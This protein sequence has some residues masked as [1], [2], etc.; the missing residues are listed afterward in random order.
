[1]KATDPF[2]GTF[3]LVPPGDEDA[4]VAVIANAIRNGFAIVLDKPDTKI[5]M[6]ILNARDAKA[7]DREVQDAARGLGDPRWHLR[8]HACGLHHA[9]TVESL[10]GD[11]AKVRGK[12]SAIVRRVTRLHGGR[13]PNIGVEPGRSRYL[14]VDVDTADELNAFLATWARADLGDLGRAP[15]IE[16]TVR[17]PGQVDEEGN[18]VHADGG[19]FWFGLPADVELPM[20]SQGVYRH[21]SGWTAMW[22]AHQILVPPSKRPEGV[23]TIVGQ[24]HPAPRWL[25][26]MIIREAT[27]RADR[28][29]RRMEDL[30]DGSGE[31][32]VWS[33]R[34]SW[35]ELLEPDGWT[36]TG[37]P[38]RCSCP[39]FT[40]PGPH[41]SKKSATGHD[42]GCD[43]YDSSTGHAPLHI[44][45][46][47]PP[48]E[49]AEAIRATGTKTFTK[50]QYVAWAAGHGGDIGLAT[51]DL[52]MSSGTVAGASLTFDPALD[53]DWEPDPPR[54]KR[55]EEPQDG[56]GDAGDPFLAPG[57]A[58]PDSDGSESPT[59]AGDDPE[60]EEGGSATDEAKELTRVD[61]LRA[62]M[63]GS[64]ALD[65]IEDPEPLI[66]GFL[67]L[68]TVA[69]VTGKSGHGKSFVMLD[70]ACS[71]AT[72][73]PW[74]GFAT[75]AGPVVYMVAEGLRGVKKR[76]RAWE[77]RH[78]GGQ[79]ISDDRLYLLKIPVQVNDREGWAAFVQILREIGPVMVILD[80]Q[81]R[82]TVGVDEND[83]KEMGIFVDR[84]ELVRRKT[85]ACVITVHHLGHQGEHGRGS[86]AVIGALGSELRVVKPGKGKLVVETSKQKDD[87]ELAPLKFV[88]DPEGDSV[89]PAPDGWVPEELDPFETP[90]FV[91]VPAKIR[92]FRLIWDWL[93]QN[94]QGFTKAEA[95]TVIR[96]R[97]HGGAP[98]E[99]PRVPMGKS[100][101]YRAFGEMVTE[102]WLKPVT[103]AKGTES[104]SRFK[105][106]PKAAREQGFEAP[107]G[108]SEPDAESDE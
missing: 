66:A 106:N 79:R 41:A 90:T 57:A 26:G 83:A 50:I 85:G 108:P 95:W 78:N 61:A 39:I 105:V 69:R 9:M 33:A 18:A 11:P 86:T 98:D 44:W 100:Y 30:P 88:L 99:E 93:S 21:P 60:G 40:A 74:H 70:M 6:C 64:A 75:T 14:V 92:A 10:G 68:D 27:E 15:S 67:D 7:A 35:A 29:R 22:D 17:S 107:E 32:D 24:S 103:N 31:I 77:A 1:M 101:F 16:L 28:V 3:G 23:Y 84:L 96:Q 5:P 51:R 65:E 12:V 52:G 20:D 71:V 43:R 47:N 2:V 81:A 87:E 54:T 25:T 38:D 46:D 91:P 102:G 73:K 82:I 62:Q 76:L 63:V 48:E 58:N 94:R 34:T 37:L 55:A 45:T 59:A 97:D 104:V 4:L 19:H 42:I 72:G 53:V 56:P 80:T 49:L 13:L 8:R 89:V 36:D